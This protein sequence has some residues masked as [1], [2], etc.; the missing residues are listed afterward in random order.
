MAFLFTVEN[1]T[2]KPYDET[3]QISPF[4]EIWE[5]D[6]LPNKEYALE[7]FTYIEFMSRMLK[8]NPYRGYSPDKRKEVLKRDIITKEGWEEDELILQGLEKMRMF[9][10]EAS[11][12]FTL[13]TSALNAKS[14]LEKF[15]DDFDFNERTRTGT[16]ILK[17]KD[18]TG[19]LLDVDKVTTSLNALK[20]KVE[21]ELFESVK[22]RGQKSIS[23]FA[24]PNS[25]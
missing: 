17:P 4:K 11:P 1:K 10:Q 14:K 6:T 3:L 16:L 21:E 2:V 15:L 19:A 23:P 25:L 24:D 13:Y 22:V 8:T 5:R 7:D 18:A 12:T 9:Q 20:K